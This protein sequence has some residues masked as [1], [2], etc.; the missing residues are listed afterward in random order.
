MEQYNQQHM[1]DQF[2]SLWI[3]SKLGE[4]ELLTL[5]SFADKGHHIHLWAYKE[6]KNVPENV[7]IFDANTIIPESQ[8][9]KYDEN[10]KIDWGK[11]SYAGFSDIFR[12]K[13]LYEYG[14]WWIDMDVT[15]LKKFEIE[16]AYFF[17]NHWML[18]VVGNVM[19]CPPKSELMLRCYERAIVEVNK[20][21]TDWHKPITIL[22]EEIERL[23][24]MHYRKLGLFNVDMQHTVQPYL[25]GNFPF[26]ND[27]LGVH[28]INSS[29]FNYK[30]G[31][32]FHTLLKQYKIKW[33]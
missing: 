25:T 17:R 21:N 32:T 9:F 31:S 16:D 26:P 10:G 12:Y 2:H 13:L 4:T 18:P 19:K 28:W 30:R 8:V 7:S 3:G 20:E 14:G 33:F 6:I 29:K 15:C 5:K 11:G 27:W 24:L 1:T 23:N 22:N